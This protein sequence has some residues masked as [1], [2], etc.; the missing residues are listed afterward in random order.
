METIFDFNPTPKEINYYA[1]GMNKVEYESFW[2]VNG[3]Y[4]HLL[5]MLYARKDDRYK[6]YLALVEDSD[7]NDFNRLILHD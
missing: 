4:K 2:N 7:R 5:Y 6:R 3:K 1:S